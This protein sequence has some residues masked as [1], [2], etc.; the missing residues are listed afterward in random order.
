M[1][2]SVNLTKTKMTKVSHKIF[3]IITLILTSSCDVFKDFRTDNEKPKVRFVDLDGNPHAVQLKTPS[4]N[5]DALSKQGNLT[6][7]KLITQPEAKVSSTPMSQ[8][9]YAKA[10]SALSQTLAMPTDISQTAPNPESTSLEA[11][12]NQEVE[13]EIEYDLT[14]EGEAVVKKSAQKRIA[15]TDRNIS[16]PS[17]AALE[18]NAPVVK[19]ESGVKKGIYV[20]AGSFNSEIH[21]QNHLKKIKKLVTKS[22]KLNIQS[23]EVNETIYHRVLVG[24][25]ANKKA[26]NSMISKLKQ[27]GQKSILIKVKE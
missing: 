3:F 23:A 4:Q 12:E 18:K 10:D 22:T 8:N 19:S 11:V 1:L 26:A 21:A 17:K 13:E 2:L 27:K 25:F 9:K 15:Q 5:I 14:D 7:Q 16:K 6:E 24:P 20:Q